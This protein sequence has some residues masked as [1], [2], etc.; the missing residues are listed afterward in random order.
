MD[1]LGISW[2]EDGSM[3]DVGTAR[4]EGKYVRE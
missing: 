1:R 4:E 2:E 3:V